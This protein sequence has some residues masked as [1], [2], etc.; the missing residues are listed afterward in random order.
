MGTQY[1]GAL[2]RR[3]ED[4]RLLAG[5]GRYVDDL[6]PAGCLHAAVLRSLHAHARIARLRLDRAPAHPGRMGVYVFAGLG[7][8][9]QPLPL[10][11]SPPPPLQTRVGFR[12]KTAVQYALAKD[13]VRHVGEPI[14]V[15]VA[16]DPYLAHDALD[17]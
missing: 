9:L 11:G 8:V 4:P 5:R 1:V 16:T 13:R 2:V 15:L 12:L 7:D 10:A 17:L 3:R 6:R 14:A